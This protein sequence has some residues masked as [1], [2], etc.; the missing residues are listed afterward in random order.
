MQDAEYKIRWALRE[1][2]I[3]G[4]NHAMS[5]YWKTLW[6]MIALYFLFGVTVGYLICLCAKM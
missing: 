2:Y 1:A 3:E 6:S 4:F 5:K